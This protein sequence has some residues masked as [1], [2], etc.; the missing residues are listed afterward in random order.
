V[1]TKLFLICGLT[2]AAYSQP[3]VRAVPAGTIVQVRTSQ[4]IDSSAGSGQLFEA[5]V[6]HDVRDP[7][8]RLVIPVGSPAELA[9][10]DVSKHELALDLQSIVIGGRRY[11]MFSHSATYPKQRRAALV[12][13]SALGNL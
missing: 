12:R 10:R 11:Q 7:S 9:V 6:A 5:V 4:A 13:T 2:C 1:R 8:G 3:A